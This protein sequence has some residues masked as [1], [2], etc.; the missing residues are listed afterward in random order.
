MISTYFG[1]EVFLAVDEKVDGN[2]D[3]LVCVVASVWLVQLLLCDAEGR[4]FGRGC[5]RCQVKAAYV[6]I[7]FVLNKTEHSQS[8]AMCMCRAT[9]SAYLV[10]LIQRQERRHLSGDF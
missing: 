8:T 10:V 5:V 4:S 3:T 7:N 6:I 1:A 2:Y 9:P